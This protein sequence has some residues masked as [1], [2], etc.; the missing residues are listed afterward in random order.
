MLRVLKFINICFYFLIEGFDDFKYSLR[1]FNISFL[2]AVNDI[3]LRYKRSIIGPFWITLNTLI[4]IS[5]IGFI[6][7]QI[8]NVDNKFFIPYI[9][10]GLILWSFFSMTLTEGCMSFVSGE[11][12]VKQ[13]KLPLFIHINRV[14][15]RNIFVF[16]HIIPILA[17]LF[18]FFDIRFSGGI[19]M[20]VLGFIILIGN[21]VWLTL[22]F[23][24]LSSRYRDLPPLI[25][26][27]LQV[28]FYFTPI[29]W[30]VDL[31]PHRTIIFL[32]FNPLYHLIEIVREPFMG[33]TASKISWTFCIVAFVF[34]NLFT[35]I[36]F[37]KYK[38]RIIYW[39]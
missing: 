16:I 26:N 5:T 35:F 12:I 11:N 6:F 21:L 8:L 2:Y 31:I 22:L 39:L 37:G 28:I 32:Q 23:S 18:I 7:G 1:Y 38:K 4:L 13:I 36:F 19:I 27:A 29:M 33:N 14:L 15:L 3:K 20:S 17:L 34:G 9:S 10:I 25:S 30:M 24:I